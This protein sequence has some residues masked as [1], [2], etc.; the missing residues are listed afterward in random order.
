LFPATAGAGAGVNSQTSRLA[1]RLLVLAG[2]SPTKHTLPFLLFLVVASAC[3]APSLMRAP[4]ED[5]VVNRAVTAMW[6]DD[7]RRRAEPGDWLLSR[8]YSAV[9]DL[10]V[11]GTRGEEL[12]HAS[13]YD[14]ER[15][16]AIEAV[17]SGVREVPLEALLARN[18]IVIVVRPEGLDATERRAAVARARAVVGKSF[19]NLGLVG[20]PSDERFYCTELVAWASRVEIDGFVITP[21]ALLERGEV[22]YLSGARE[23]GQVQAAA[24]D[25]SLGAPAVASRV[26]P[27]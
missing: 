16:M 24:R 5:P 7:I 17:A 22:V 20:L 14:G 4:P 25:R 19:D 11:L 12:S 8:S 18:Q 6:A 9:G 10:I 26:A 23:D 15:G 13:I 21:S 1:R 2:V 27:L 3:A